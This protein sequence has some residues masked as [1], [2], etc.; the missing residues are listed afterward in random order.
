M[1]QYNLLGVKSNG[2]L[3]Y[4]KG[5]PDRQSKSMYRF[6]RRL[7]YAQGIFYKGYF[8]TITIAERKL[9]SFPV[10]A[11]QL[12]FPRRLYSKGASLKYDRFKFKYCYKDVMDDP[13]GF[14]RKRINVIQQWCRRN[15]QSKPSFVWRLERGP[16]TGRLHV[17]MLVQWK[18]LGTRYPNWYIDKLF[19]TFSCGYIQWE[20]MDSNYNKVKN[21]VSKY[22]TKKALDTSK[23]VRRYG[24]SRDIPGYKPNENVFYIHQEVV[25]GFLRSKKVSNIELSLDFYKSFIKK[26]KAVFECYHRVDLDDGRNILIAKVEFVPFSYNVFIERTYQQKLKIS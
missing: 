25:L 1:Q 9:T 16:R 2:L 10:Q 3:F 7:R 5:F 22:F 11:W 8:A 20:A 21:Y 12:A 26:Y 14:V 4:M 6:E 17:H 23:G 15:F 18:E 24:T 13:S 19:R